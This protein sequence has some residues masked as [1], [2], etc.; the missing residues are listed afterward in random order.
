MDAAGILA[1]IDN[2][3]AMVG[4]RYQQFIYVLQGAFSVAIA[5]N[6]LVIHNI[7]QR[8]IEIGTEAA[9]TAL[10]DISAIIETHFADLTDRALQDALTPA[11]QAVFA[12]TGGNAMLSY[13]EDG[14][15]QLLK[16]I[17]NQMQAEI[18][19][20]IAS[21]RELNFGMIASLSTSGG[22][23]SAIM[24]AKRNYLMSDKNYINR[25]GQRRSALTHIQSIARHYLLTLYNEWVIYAATQAGVKVFQG[26]HSDPNHYGH[27]LEF[28][29]DA[30]Q[31]LPLYHDFRSELL[32]PNSNLL[33]SRKK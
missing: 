6:T 31:G 4:A 15:K 30:A 23:E 17:H 5:Q 28:A 9:N 18:E 20:G 27:G 21:L 29:L 26:V 33:V 10:F 19:A 13:L 25:A 2:A 11:E 32:H 24:D 12:A 1:T 14:K 3:T 8:F 7:K 22:M 16:A